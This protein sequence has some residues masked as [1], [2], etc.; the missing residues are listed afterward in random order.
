MKFISTRGNFR[1][2]KRIIVLSEFW[3]PSSFLNFPL[4]NFFRHCF[5]INWI[6][7]SMKALAVTSA[8]GYDSGSIPQRGCRRKLC[9]TGTSCVS[10]RL[11]QRFAMTSIDMKILKENEAREGET[12]RDSVQSLARAIHSSSAREHIN[13]VNSVI[14]IWKRHEDGI[15]TLFA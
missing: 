11:S 14:R 8:R 1:T 4:F 9:W 15:R 5:C 12:L 13:A 7:F 6:V 2:V 10:C 3:S